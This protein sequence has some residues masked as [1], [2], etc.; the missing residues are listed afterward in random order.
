MKLN[1]NFLTHNVSD[2]QVMVDL[3]GKFH[4]IVTNNET[5]AFIVD[6]LKEDTTKQEIVEKILN[7]FDV[8]EYVAQEDVE[9]ILNKLESIG[10]LE[11]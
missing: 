9:R 1:K 5:A 4:G 3:T 6:C 11:E 2:E 7:E 10:A 8:E